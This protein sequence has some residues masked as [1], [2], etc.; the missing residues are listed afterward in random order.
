M[1]TST[2]EPSQLLDPRDTLNNQNNQIDSQSEHG[3]NIFSYQKL[4]FRDFKDLPGELQTRIQLNL[5]NQ[6]NQTCLNVL[7]RLSK[8]IHQEPFTYIS[9]VLMMD[10][11]LNDDLIKS[12]DFDGFQLLKQMGKKFADFKPSFELQSV[13][14]FPIDCHTKEILFKTCDHLIRTVAYT[15]LKPNLINKILTDSKNYKNF[16]DSEGRKLYILLH[17]KLGVEKDDILTDEDIQ[18]QLLLFSEQKAHNTENLHLQG[19]IMF[20][21]LFSALEQLQTNKIEPSFDLKLIKKLIDN[22]PPINLDPTVESEIKK[23]KCQH[24][25]I[26]Q[27]SI[28]KLMLPKY[29]QTTDEHPKPI[30]LNYLQKFNSKSILKSTF[31]L[32]FLVSLTLLFYF[33]YRLFSYY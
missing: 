7:E 19:Y 25:P 21:K 20:S 15:Y 24:K 30:Y 9:A 11:I 17:D 13:L 4:N 28:V 5:A 10:I 22:P 14:L 27:K 2:I 16:V 12:L 23:F 3:R 8:Q 1:A 18:I 31:Y 32:A 29:L 33:I 26:S 6:R